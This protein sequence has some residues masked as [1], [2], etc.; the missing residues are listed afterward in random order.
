MSELLD[1]ETL[2]ERLG[3]GPI[4]PRK[5]VEFGAAIAEALAAAH[6]RGIVHRDQPENLFLQRDGRPKILDFGIAKLTMAEAGECR[7]GTDGL[8]PDRCRCR[9]G[10]A[11]LYGA[12]AGP[13]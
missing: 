2:R 13:W 7:G 6:A 11:G 4:A 12:R 9:R 10:H 1:G 5:A 3:R 8:G